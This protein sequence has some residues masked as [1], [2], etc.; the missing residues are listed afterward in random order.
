VC[1]STSECSSSD[2]WWQL[3]RI[4][5]T[6]CLRTATV[7]WQ[8]SHQ[9]RHHTA[10]TRSSILQLLICGSQ[11]CSTLLEASVHV[12]GLMW[13]VGC[14]LRFQAPSDHSAAGRHHKRRLLSVPSHG[15]CHARTAIPLLFPVYAA[16][17]LINVSPMQG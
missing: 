12:Q 16:A 9:L 4:G 10:C 8:V 15:C 3:T 1:P 5:R 11:S 14:A 13:T 17:F 6:Q 2:P 7:C